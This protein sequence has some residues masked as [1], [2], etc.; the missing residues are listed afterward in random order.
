MEVC[1]TGLRKDIA[2]AFFSVV[3]INQISPLTG[4]KE[5]VNFIICN[6]KVC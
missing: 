2:L 5:I 4:C 1:L 3:A 6:K